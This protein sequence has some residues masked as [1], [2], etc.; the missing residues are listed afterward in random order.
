MRHLHSIVLELW[1][2]LASKKVVQTELGEDE[3]EVL[4]AV[5]RREGITIKEAARRALL[6]WSMM[7]IDLTQDPL[8]RLKPVRFREKI[9]SSEIDRF[10]YHAK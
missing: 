4:S 5:A 8:F 7:G 6:E 2:S 10:L 1:V 3:Y 9:R